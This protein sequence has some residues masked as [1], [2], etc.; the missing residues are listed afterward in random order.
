MKAFLQ[1]RKYA[2]DVDAEP[3]LL[4][5]SKRFA[6]FEEISTDTLREWVLDL[7]QGRNGYK[8]QIA[9]NTAAKKITYVKQYWEWCFANNHTR[10]RNLAVHQEILPKSQTTKSLRSAENR[11][12]RPYSVEQCWRLHQA[13][14]EDGYR[15]LDDLILLAMYTGCR[16]GELCDLRIDNVTDEYIRV[17]DAKT[18]S[19]DREI[20]I[21]REIQQAVERLKQT[22]TDGYLFSEIK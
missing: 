9:R 20:P 12:Y 14:V 10:A 15:Y 17:T 6:Y 16:I 7:M 18:Y 1:D 4:D 2:D 11:S 3:V 8:R 13:A 22:S 5:W 21:H 19:G